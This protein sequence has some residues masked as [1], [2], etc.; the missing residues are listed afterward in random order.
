MP[1]SYTNRGRNRRPRV[2]RNTVPTTGKR[3]E[4]EPRGTGDDEYYYI[5]AR[6]RDVEETGI[7]K[8][9]EAESVRIQ[10][11]RRHRDL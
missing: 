7:S 6:R 5:R 4:T 11:P 10:N 9:P 1:R 2:R 8:P 3:S